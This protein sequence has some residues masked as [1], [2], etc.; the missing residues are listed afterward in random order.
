MRGI[1]NDPPTPES[2]DDVSNAAE[3]AQMIGWVC[4][5]INGVILTRA[6]LNRRRL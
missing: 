6:I 5:A 1:N 3:I 4:V 2:E